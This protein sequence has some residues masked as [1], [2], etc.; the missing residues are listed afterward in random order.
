M[1]MWLFAQQLVE[2]DHIENISKLCTYGP[3]WGEST[4]DK[5]ILL[6]KGQ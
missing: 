5:W 2:A 1:A 3:L 6:T 4:G